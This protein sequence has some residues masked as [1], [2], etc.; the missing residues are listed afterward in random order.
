MMHEKTL[1]K[2]GS[3]WREQ[4]QLNLNVVKIELVGY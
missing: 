2:V 3:L 1:A 4:H